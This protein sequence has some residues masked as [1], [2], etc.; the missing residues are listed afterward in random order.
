MY[1]TSVY[2][3]SLETASSRTRLKLA[4]IDKEFFSNGR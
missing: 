2:S 1:F 3:L 4:R